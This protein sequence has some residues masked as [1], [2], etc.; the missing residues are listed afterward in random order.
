MHTKV[1]SSSSRG[2][3]LVITL[4][5]LTVDCRA[6]RSESMSQGTCQLYSLLLEPVAAVVAAAAAVSLCEHRTEAVVAEHSALQL[7]KSMQ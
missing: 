1:C 6:L 2:K 3:A 7:T 5:G 4:L